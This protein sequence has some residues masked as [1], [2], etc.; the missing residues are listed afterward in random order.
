MRERWGWSIPAGAQRW[1][2][3]VEM[4]LAQADQLPVER[5]M[6]VRYEHLVADPRSELER[7]LNFLGERW[8][9]SVL[10]HA[11][12]PHDG[13]AEDVAQ[14]G[15]EVTQESV[16]RWQKQMSRIDLYRFKRNAGKLLRRLGYR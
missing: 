1:A 2:E 16:G 5:Y 3:R 4:V 6:E 15:R 7:V 8:E 14:A 12:Q 13:V 11:N 9:P 10:D